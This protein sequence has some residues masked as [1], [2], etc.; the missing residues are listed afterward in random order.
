[1]S[2]NGGQE[3]VYHVTVLTTLH[4]LIPQ[5]MPFFIAA[6]GCTRISL[7]GLSVRS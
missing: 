3:K 6:V 2:D 1:M 7:E 5:T 4:V